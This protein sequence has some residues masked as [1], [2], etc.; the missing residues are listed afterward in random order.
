MGEVDFF[1][2]SRWFNGRPKLVVVGHRGCGKNKTLAIGEAPDPR[3]SIRE[4]TIASFNVAANNGADFVEFDVQVTRD[5]HP[6]IFHD[7]LIITN[8]NVSQPIRDLTLDEFLSIGFQQHGTQMQQSG[9][10]LLRRASDGSLRPWTV[11]IEDSLC[12]LKQAFE[13]VHPSVGFNIELKFDDVQPTADE[14]LNRV[15]DAV[16]EDVNKYSSGRR[17]YFSS[18]HPDAVA[19][20]RRKQSS[21]P[22]FFLTDGGVHTYADPRRNSIEAAIDVCKKNNLQGIVSEVKAVLH[23]ANVVTQVKEAGLQFL[24]YGELNNVSEALHKQEQFGVDGVIVDHVLEMV[25][26]ARKLDGLYSTPNQ[27]TF[28]PA[29]KAVA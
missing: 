28:S 23:D 14:E 19:L 7:D 11:T 12:T 6:V 17:I 27:P 13:Q 15:I 5:G 16:I 4:N 22:V 26:V 1:G 25:T 2:E 20:L 10:L 3:P 21:H 9:K 24:T 8:D 18:F 29:V